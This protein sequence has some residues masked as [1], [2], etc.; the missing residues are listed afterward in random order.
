M[1]K[2]CEYDGSGHYVL[3]PRITNCM[4]CG[5]PSRIGVH[6]SFSYDTRTFYA[7]S[8]AGDI[9]DVLFNH[10]K[11]KQARLRLSCDDLITIAK[12]LSEKIDAA[13]AAPGR[14]V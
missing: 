11:L 5:A 10:P 4:T 13:L 8:K 2:R 9:S 1:K 6:K 3:S 14:D 12:V 7:P